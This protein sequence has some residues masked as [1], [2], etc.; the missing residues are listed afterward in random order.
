M[1]KLDTLFERW[2][3]TSEGERLFG[4]EV[5]VFPDL[6]DRKK[7]MLILNRLYS[8]YEA[9]MKSISTYLST[10]W[11]GIDV[12]LIT[13]ELIEYEIRYQISNVKNQVNIFFRCKKLPK[14]LMEFPAYGELVTSVDELKEV[15]P[16]LELLA[17][18]AVKE[19]HWLRLIDLT[20]Y[21]FPYQKETFCLRD[22]VQAPLLFNKEGV[23]DICIG[24]QKELEVEA[25]LKNVISEWLGINLTF[26]NFK[27]RGELLLKGQETKDILSQLEDS[28]M[29]VSSLFT[30]R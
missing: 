9:V 8:L 28:L 21:D 11:A 23:E 19:R 2:E 18:S 3:K 12:E 10:L 26:A 5:T 17:H 6:V 20:S 13:N 15:C 16:L 30:N 29:I 22:V 4:L 27:N 24:A 1:M 7:Q 14:S 25:K